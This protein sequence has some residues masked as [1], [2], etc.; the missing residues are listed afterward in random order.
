MHRN[1]SGKILDGWQ[2]CLL[3]VCGYKGRVRFFTAMK[4]FCALSQPDENT[5]AALSLPNFLTIKCG[6]MHSCIE[7]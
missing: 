4:M 3:Y 6:S 5:S 7:S 2:Q 1:S